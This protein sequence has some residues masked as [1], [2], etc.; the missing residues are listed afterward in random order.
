MLLLPSA[1]LANSIDANDSQHLDLP[2]DAAFNRHGSGTYVSISDD[3]IQV[4]RQGRRVDY[5]RIQ[6]KLRL[7]RAV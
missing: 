6:S 3:R 1:A 4:W 5:V 2:D 7:R